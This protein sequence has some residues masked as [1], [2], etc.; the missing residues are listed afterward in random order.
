MSLK[1]GILIGLAGALLLGGAIVYYGGAV[2]VSI[3]QKAPDGHRLV[4]GSINDGLRLEHDRVDREGAGNR[5][6]IDDHARHLAVMNA[7]V[8]ERHQVQ[9]D[10]SGPNCLEA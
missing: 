10:R 8:F 4:A 2:R 1:R 3:H 7:Q 9:Q 6:P 5:G